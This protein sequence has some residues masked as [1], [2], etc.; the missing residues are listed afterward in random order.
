MY[1]FGVVL[2][3]KSMYLTFY[4]VRKAPG[5]IRNTI[6]IQGLER[7]CGQCLPYFLWCN[8]HP[9]LQPLRAPS[10]CAGRLAWQLDKVNRREEGGVCLSSPCH[11]MQPQQDDDNWGQKQNRRNIIGTRTFRHG[12]ALPGVL[13]KYYSLLFSKGQTP[14]YPVTGH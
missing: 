13:L 3:F 8:D 1:R 2:T 6:T 4:S 5:A 12:G 7:S 11:K 14:H 10:P 9:L